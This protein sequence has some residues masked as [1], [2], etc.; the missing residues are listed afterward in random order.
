M[1]KRQKISLAVAVFGLSVLLALLLVELGHRQGESGAER[2][3]ENPALTRLSAQIGGPFSLTDHRGQTRTQADFAGRPMLIFFGFTYC[4][5]VCPTALDRVGAALELLQKAAPERFDALQVLFI[6]VD[7]ER[8]TPQALADYLGYFHPKILGLTGTQASID[9]VKKA[10]RVYA[11]RS[12]DTDANGH[13]LVD[14]SSFFYLMDGDNRYL[15]HFDHA[16][17]PEDLAAQ[18]RKKLSQ[19]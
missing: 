14:H 4:P 16:L 9:A 8:D 3:G 15:A 6:S 19:P 13:Y 1:P 11:A 18:L 7:P 10:Y 2:S 5:D 17:T 12:A